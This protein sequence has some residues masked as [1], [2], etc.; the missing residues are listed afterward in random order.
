MKENPEKPNK[1]DEWTFKLCTEY[2]TVKLPECHYPI[3][4]YKRFPG[5]WSFG[6]MEFLVWK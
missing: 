6:G 4:K 1:G 5:P 2:G 3:I